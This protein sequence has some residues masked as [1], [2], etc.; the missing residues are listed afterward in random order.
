M[1]PTASLLAAQAL[2]ANALGQHPAPVPEAVPQA[3][4][5]LPRAQHATPQAHDRDPPASW[6]DDINLPRIAARYL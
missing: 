5:A 3:G 2:I 4:P 6:Y 1:D